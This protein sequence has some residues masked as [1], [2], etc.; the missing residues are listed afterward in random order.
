MMPKIK[1][2]RQ[3][4]LYIFFG[5]LT[6]G[7]NYISYFMLTRW[8]DASLIVANTIAWLL[9]VLFA[10]V[11]N[12]LYVFTGSAK[13]TLLILK[14]FGLFIAARIISGLFDTASMLVLVEWL[15]VNDMIAKML[16]NLLV[17][18]INYV[19]SRWIVFRAR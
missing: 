1:K 18:I 16:V 6:V 3:I 4:L 9:A 2:H 19:L 14:E 13:G 8:L 17:I 7:V 15:S 11:T 10:Y 12:R 5:A